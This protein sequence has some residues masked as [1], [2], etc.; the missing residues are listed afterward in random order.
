MS[1]PV[2]VITDEVSQDFKIACEAASKAGAT[3]AEVRMVNGNNLMKL[4]NDELKAMASTLGDY[5][6]KCVGLSTP[7][8]KCPLLGTKLDP[9][10][11]V[12][13]FGSPFDYSQQRGLWQRAVEISEILEVSLWRVFAFIRTEVP[14]L[15]INR[16]VDE[17]GSLG[18]FAAQYG[19]KIGVENEPCTHVA[20]GFELGCFTQTV[21]LRNVGGVWDPG[22]AYAAGERDSAI[23]FNPFSSNKIFHVHVKDANAAGWAQ[24]GTG[25]IDWPGQ[26][27]ALKEVGY[28]GW[29]SLEAHYPY[30]LPQND[31]QWEAKTASA[32]KGLKTLV[33]M[34]AA[35]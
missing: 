12:D 21:N 6:L 23:A 5:K 11:P 15:Y 34:A 1:F 4:T 33:E 28:S 31:V 9:Q 35:V 24:L 14:A 27:K 29:L 17:I 2:A 18:T 32:I 10:F 22:N 19:I 20:T 3:G 13:Q 8:F 16:V 26:L 7:I 30:P 25:E